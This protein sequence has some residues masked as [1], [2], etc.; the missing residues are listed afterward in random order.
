MYI[1]PIKNLNDI[2]SLITL[3]NDIFLE[4]YP[5]ILGED[6]TRYVHELFF[7]EKYILNDIKNKTEYY[8]I[9]N[10]EENIGF[11]TIMFHPAH[12][13]VSKFYIVDKYRKNG[14]GT[15]V[16]DFIKYLAYIHNYQCIQL[17]VNR[18]NYPSIKFFEHLG[19]KRIY[20]DTI[21]IGDGYYMEDYS[22]QYDL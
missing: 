9:N 19:F 13:F 2:K 11:I 12:L 7:N 1:S 15:K 20:E 21:D 22:Y 5:L 16:F 4:Y 10:E 3:S 6:M 8:F 14:Y 17:N 18:A